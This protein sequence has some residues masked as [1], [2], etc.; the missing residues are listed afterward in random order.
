[1]NTLRSSYRAVIF[2]IGGVLV[3]T[4]DW[5]GRRLW[6]QRLGLPEWGLN[7][8]VFDGELAL[9]ASTG[10]GSDEAIWQQVAQRHH[11]TPEVLAQLRA[12]FWRGDRLNEALLA[13]VRALRPRYKTGILSNAW[14][15]MRDLN[16]QRFGLGQ[17]VDE[18][19]YS[20]ECG[21]LKPDAA[22]Y[23]YILDRL[24]AQPEQAIF[25]DDAERNILG[26]QALGMTTVRFIETHQAIAELNE[27]L[28]VSL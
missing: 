26:A 5:S 24:C 17:V 6:E 28:G 19:V 13:Y 15:E 2:D 10:A 22:S 25:V 1:M 21:L 7:A 14:A 20:F 11:L 18:T 23:R 9:C 4:E 3:R 12:D 8:L 16:V 27:L